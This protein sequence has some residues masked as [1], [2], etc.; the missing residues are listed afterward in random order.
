MR[1]FKSRSN[2]IDVKLVYNHKSLNGVSW[3]VTTVFS[4]KFIESKGLEVCYG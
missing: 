3:L 4:K 1:D 2:Q